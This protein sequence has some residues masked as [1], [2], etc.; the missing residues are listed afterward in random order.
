MLRRCAD[1]RSDISFNYVASVDIEAITARA[2]GA[3]VESTAATAPV[4]PVPA[5]PVAPAA[6]STPTKRRW[7][8][9]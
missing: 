9:G 8:F 4:A 7:W 3:P 1:P 5:A 6:E 2:E